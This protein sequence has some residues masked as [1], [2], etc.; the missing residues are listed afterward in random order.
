[1]IIYK[2]EDKFHIG[3]K[4]SQKIITTR[5]STIIFRGNRIKI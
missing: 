2:H 5:L 3:V 1:M 4:F